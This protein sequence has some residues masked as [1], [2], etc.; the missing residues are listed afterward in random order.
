MILTPIVIADTCTTPDHEATVVT[1]ATPAPDAARSL[2]TA[3]NVTVAIT[4]GPDGKLVTAKVIS[5][6]H[7]DQVDQAALEAVRATTYT[8]KVVNCQAVQSE[9]DF[10]FGFDPKSPA[11]TPKPTPSAR[12]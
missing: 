4:L 5:S 10:S 12:P 7:N 6:S 1:A 11:P 3:A 9:Y 8:P 2:K